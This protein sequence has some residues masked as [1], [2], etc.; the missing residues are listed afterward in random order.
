[1]AL[2][3][4][5]SNLDRTCRYGHGALESFASWF[6]LTG[7]NAPSS[8]GRPANALQQM[9]SPTGSLLALRVWR[10]PTCGYVELQD[11]DL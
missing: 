2:N 1:M 10:C 4:L 9:A 7:V 8:R 6:A 5:Q 3:A 11:K